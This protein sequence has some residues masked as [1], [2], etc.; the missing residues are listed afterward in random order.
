MEKIT[1]NHPLSKSK[2]LLEEN[3]ET[4]KRLFPEIVTEGKIDKEAL[5]TLLGEELETENERFSFT[6]NGKQQARREAQ[7]TSTGTLRPCREE[8]VDFDT[9]QNLYIEGDNLEVLKLLQKSYHGKVKMIYIDPPYNTGNDFIYPDDYSESLKTYLKYTGQVDEEGRKFSTNSDSDG[10]YHSKWLNMMYPRLKLARNLLRNDGVI[11][12]SIDDREIHNLKQLLNQ[13]FGEHNFRAEVAWQKKYSVSN[14]FK[15]IASIRDSILIYSKTQAF[16]N[17]LLPR[18]EES[19]SRYK[20]PDNDPRGV[21]K[22]VDYWNQASPSQRPNLVYD[23]VNPN[24]GEVIKPTK[25]AWKYSKEGHEKHIEEN[26]IWWGKDG[27]N[28][29]PALK[30]FL[31]EVNDGL[32]PHNWWTHQDAGH[33]DEAKKEIERLFNGPSPFDTVKPSKLLKRIC[34][35]AG[36]HDHDLVLDFFSGSSSTAHAILELASEEKVNARYVMVQLPE[37]T[38]PKK[39]AFKAGYK[40]ISDIGKERIR[41]VIKKLAEEYPQSVQKIDLGFKVLKLDSSNIKTWDPDY[42][43]LEETLFNSVDNIKKDRDEEDLLFEILLKFGLDLSLPIQKHTQNG[44]T[45]YDVG[46]G[47]LLVCLSQD[48]QKETVEAIGK[49]K[50]ELAPETCRVVFKDSGFKDDAAKTNAMQILK[51]FGITEVRSI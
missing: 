22:A 8:S 20:N 12:V 24:T 30:L 10:R 35:V 43:Q 15:G 6:W 26:R 17:G 37:P 9:T 49:L 34:M 4:L 21:W 41:R 11:F 3:I 48:I 40:K 27:K 46:M 29:V 38:D 1:P 13:I 32:I 19:L 23:I 7:K 39:D 45:I 42:D 50:E 44:N 28:S 33:T 16:K 25:K 31:S 47:A 18:S 14:N 51:R 5:L 2:D 36:L